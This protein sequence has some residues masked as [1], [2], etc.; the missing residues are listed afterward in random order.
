MANAVITVNGVSSE[1]VT[2][3]NGCFTF[4]PNTSGVFYLS[5]VKDGMTLTP[6]ICTVTA[7]NQSWPETSDVTMAMVFTLPLILALCTCLLTR[8]KR[9]H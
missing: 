2:D 8:K 6:P 7:Q 9:I 1:I 3:E 4:T 5:A